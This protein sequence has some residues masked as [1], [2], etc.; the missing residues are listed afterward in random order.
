MNALLA[1][2]A[3]KVTPNNKGWWGYDLDYL[4]FGPKQAKIVPF[5]DVQYGAQ[6][7][8]SAAPMPITQGNKVF[9]SFEL[10]NLSAVPVDMV[11]TTPYGVRTYEGIRPGKTM[12]AMV[13]TNASSI[14]AG[15]VTVEATG[16]V[17]GQQVT[18]TETAYY[19]A[20]TMTP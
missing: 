15:H 5:V 3:L 18:V 2:G 14:P 7:D 9:L 12:K 1:S 16:V 13:N 10:T 11:V 17:G 20:Y 4:A 6:V 19:G 8:V